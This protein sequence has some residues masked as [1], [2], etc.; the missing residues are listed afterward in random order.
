M[1]QPNGPAG[2]GFHGLNLAYV[3][4]MYEGFRALAHPARTYPLT[5]TTTTTP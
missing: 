5:I 3:L 1:S 4:E 2:E